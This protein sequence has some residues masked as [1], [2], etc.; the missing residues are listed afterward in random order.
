MTHKSSTQDKEP[1]GIASLCRHGCRTAAL[2]LQT[3]TACTA[4]DPSCSALQCGHPRSPGGCRSFGLRRTDAAPVPH[5]GPTSG[6][7]PRSNPERT[8]ACS[9]DA[10]AIGETK[11]AAT[12]RR[13]IELKSQDKRARLPRVIPREPTLL[14]LYLA[15]F[16]PVFPRFL[17]VFTVS[18]RRFQRAPSRNPG[19]RN[20]GKNT[21]TRE[22]GPSFDTP[23]A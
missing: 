6:C 16:F 23:D 14:R 22:L 5:Q 11:G 20:G 9:N 17:R 2:C 13:R 18:T 19:P 15:H 21:K 3:G 8:L 4:H 10:F 7:T 12:H 1:R